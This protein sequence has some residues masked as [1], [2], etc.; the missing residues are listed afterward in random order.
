[1]ASYTREQRLRAC[2]LYE[3][4]DR[5]A[6]AVV[7]ELG[8]PASRHSVR[9]WYR[10]YALERY[11]GVP[12]RVA[13]ARVPAPAGGYPEGL[14][15]AAVEHFLTHGRCVQRTC[16]CLGYPSPGTLRK[17]VDRADPSRRVPAA[18]GVPVAPAAG[19]VRGLEGRDPGGL[20][21]PTMDDVTGRAV[22]AGAADAARTGKA[23][24]PAAKAA[25][26]AAGKPAAGPRKAAGKAGKAVEPA[27][28]KPAAR[29]GESV[30][31]ADVEELLR[32]IASLREQADALRREADELRGET[33]SLRDETE[34]LRDEAESLRGKAR[35]RC[36]ELRD[37]EIDLEIRRGTIEL[38]GKEPGAD[39]DNLSNRE[40]SLLA[41][42]V[43]ERTGE[44]VGSLLAR[45]GVA[46][47]TYYY[48]RRV[49]DLPDK[50]GPLLD[51]IR[52]VFEASGRRYGYR[53]VWAA[54]RLRGT[55]VSARRVMRLMTGN[56]LV[57]PFKSSRRY[58]SYKGE[59]SDAPANIVNRDFHADA[60]N[61]LWVTDITEFSIPA[62][63]VYLSPVIDCYDGMP[64]AWTIGTSPNSS[65]SNGML[66]KACAALGPGE[67][68]VIHSD[69]GCH[70]R[71]DGWISICE[72]N[73][74]VRSMS[75][76]GCS[77]DN[78]AAEG[79][80][81]RLKQEFFHKRSFAGVSLREFIRR[82]DEYMTW[83]RDERIK[84][85][86]GTSIAA[87]RRELGLMA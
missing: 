85:E 26:K 21:E 1:M 50:D 70:Y 54:L 22:R 15:R 13:P 58:S 59:L 76:K 44:P 30:S 52:G 10:R 77:P 28:G 29:A 35:E 18:G 47:S 27:P 14:R 49:R 7:R 60:P 9:A 53:R 16:R 43:A 84:T 4:L 72:E 37:L 65:L 33:E 63:K 87:R 80:F 42:R 57:P 25:G 62:G 66:R 8:Y 2:E 61:R 48:H 83:Y 79:F 24:G 41:D 39:P 46:R 64:V 73:G 56:G 34:S 5:S 40:R 23:G 71:W 82:L 31:A 55:V 32:V 78:A 45:V 51:E 6:T 74:L 38:L 19:S 11:G 12:G 86:F 17:W 36:R 20:E 75:A 67:R 69:R 3:R 68:P 81:G